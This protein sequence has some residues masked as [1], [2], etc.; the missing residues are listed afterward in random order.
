[1]KRTKLLVVA[2]LALVICLPGMALANLVA[3]PGFESRDFTDWNTVPA[4]SGAWLYVFSGEFGISWP[5]SGSYAAAFGAQESTPDKITQDIQTVD[6]QKYE[7][8][9]WLQN[10]YA[11]NNSNEFTAAWNGTPVVSVVNSN[12]FG[13]TQY[14]VPVTATGTS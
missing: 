13:Y 4:S 7:F 8:S 11:S 6:G 12:L 10:V 14:V 9:F 2:V 1:M 5:H 3:N